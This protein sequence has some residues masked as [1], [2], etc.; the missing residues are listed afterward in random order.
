[1]S[2]CTFF[3]HYTMDRC[4]VQA[5]RYCHTRRAIRVIVNGRRKV[6]L[7]WLEHLLGKI[8]LTERSYRLT[9]NNTDSSSFRPVLV[10]F[11]SEF[12]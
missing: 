2:Y 4:L 10:I 3:D 9:T 11:F 6:F 7:E 1:M 8:I 5:L 12:S